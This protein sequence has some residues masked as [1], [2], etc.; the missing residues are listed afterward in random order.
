MLDYSPI[1]FKLS[2]IPLAI[3]YRPESEATLQSVAECQFV[4]L[5]INIFYL[6]RL[7]DLGM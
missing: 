3:L 2:M 1:D 4:F 5:N 6:F 7:F